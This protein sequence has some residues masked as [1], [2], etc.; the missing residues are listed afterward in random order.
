MAT[1]R[2]HRRTALAL[3]A[4]AAAPVPVLA[5]TGKYTDT[6]SAIVG[7]IKARL[8]LVEYF[9]FTC[10]ACARFVAAATQPLQSAYIAPGLLAFEY[11]NLVRDPLDMTA[12][13]L[14][15]ADGPAGFSGH[16]RALMLAQPNWLARVRALPDAVIERWYEGSVA[17]RGARIAADSGL[18]ALMQRRGV[19][20][21]RQRAALASAASQTALTRM[22][23]MAERDGV[24]STPSFRLNGA[25]L[26]GVHDWAALKTR[27]DQALKSA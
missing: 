3:I 14:A 6:G 13:L 22:T 24:T 27:L 26:P 16:Y 23:N 2:I 8:Q 12:A 20:P 11:R 19:G 18:A 5:A 25:A 4:A 1:D 9:S 17:E 10:P 21:A 15:R 7:N